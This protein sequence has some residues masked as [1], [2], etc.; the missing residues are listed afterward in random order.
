MSKEQDISKELEFIQ[1]F[2]K[3]IEVEEQLL[4]QKAFTSSNPS[5]ILK[6]SSIV[7]NRSPKQK[8]FLLDPYFSNIGLGY[9]NK[10]INIT[11][12]TLRQMAKEPIISSIITTRVEQVVNFANFTEDTSKV[13]WTLKK[14]SPLSFDNK[15]TKDIYTEEEKDL[16]R[17]TIDFINNCGRRNRV[18]QGDNF[19]SFLRKLVPDSLALDQATFEVIPTRNFK[20]YEFFATDGATYRFLNEQTARE[21]EEVNNY[22]PSYGQLFQ[23]QISEVFY[24]WELGFIIRNYSTNIYNNG[25][26][27]SELEILIKQITWM[28]YSD[29]YMGNFFQNGSNPKGFFAIEGNVSED[30]LAEFRSSWRTQTA[31]VENA[32]KIP[33]VQGGKINWVDMQKSN[34]DMEFSKWK[35]FLIKICCAFYKIDPKEIHFDFGGQGVTY[36][37]KET[38]E[39]KIKYSKD[40]GLNPILRTVERWINNLIVGPYTDRRFRFEF[41]GVNVDDKAAILESDL[42][43]LSQG[44]LSWRDFRRKYELST[45]LEEGDFLLNPTWIQFLQAKMGMGGPNNQVF[46]GGTPD[47]NMSPE[48]SGFNPFNLGE[49]NPFM[50]LEND[51][52]FLK[53]LNVFME[54]AFKNPEREKIN[55]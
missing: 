46:G 18:Y 6:A 35:E 9:R 23:G 16:M 49:G 55:L 32:F 37:G 38:E 39:S 42:K 4:L 3:E 5:H 28:L 19:E 45:E 48:S 51:N 26:G 47:F 24:P 43:Q 34:V 29:Q 52:P 17:S 50:N 36:E 41:T 30:K 11:Y 8:S 53:D 22:F 25:Y 2:K 12:G 20:P 54:K 1:Q 40:K 21:C 14:N 7:E 33:V 44:G 13:G 31:G 27:T 15:V 10:N